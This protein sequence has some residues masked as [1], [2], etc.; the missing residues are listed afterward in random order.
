[1]QISYHRIEK[2]RGGQQKSDQDTLDELVKRR[3]EVRSKLDEIK[4]QYEEA[5]PKD[6]EREI[7]ML[8]GFAYEEYPGDATRRDQHLRRTISDAVQQLGRRSYQKYLKGDALEKLVARYEEF[9]NT[10]G[11]EDLKAEERS[12]APAIRDLRN[13]IAEQQRKEEWEAEL[14]IFNEERERLMM[15]LYEAMAVIEDS[16]SDIAEAGMDVS[17]AMEKQPPDVKKKYD[18]LRFA[19]QHL[20]KM[21]EPVSPSYSGFSLYEGLKEIGETLDPETSDLFFRR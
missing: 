5:F 9:R 19:Y 7:N 17:L 16:I 18:V 2:K 11:W 21:T 14:K 13:K 15:K 12:L 3:K 4:A 10:H 20:E 1:M 8:Y 6:I